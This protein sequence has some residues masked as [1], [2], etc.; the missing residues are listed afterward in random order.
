M[1]NHLEENCITY[2]INF[3]ILVAEDRSLYKKRGFQ[4]VSNTVRWLLINDHQ[5]L[6]VM[7]GKLDKSLMVKAT[8]KLKWNDGLLDLMGGVF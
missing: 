1:L 2:E 4:S 5:S 3:L 7:H 8:G 6:G